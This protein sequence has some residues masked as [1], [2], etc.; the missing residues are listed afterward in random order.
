M[1]RRWYYIWGTLL[2]GCVLAAV[3]FGP[4]DEPSYQ[5][6]SLGGWLDFQNGTNGTDAIFSNAIVHMGSNAVPYLVKYIQYEGPD[7]EIT[8]E[9]YLNTKYPKSYI[10]RYII[11]QLQNPHRRKSAA[12][13]A[14]AYLQP[15]AALAAPLLGRCIDYPEASYWTVRALCNLG[16]PGAPYILDALTNKIDT[17]ALQVTLALKNCGTNASFAFPA[18]IHNLKSS[19]RPLSQESAMALKT[20][21]VEPDMVIPALQNILNDPDRA[22]RIRIINALNDYGER[23]QPIVAPFTNDPAPLIREAA[24][25]FFRNINFNAKIANPP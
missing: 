5:G 21:G 6:R 20:I 4:S 18:L 15:H 13:K 17:S 1:R 2:A 24:S 9:K 12:A 22:V 7:W 25:N 3:I 10:G 23:A 8:V 11:K 19:F 14:F 16:E